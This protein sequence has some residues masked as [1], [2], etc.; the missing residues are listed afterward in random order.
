MVLTKRPRTLRRHPGQIAFPGGMIESTDANALDAALREAR[1]EIGFRP[2]GDVSPVAL[3]PVKTLT[4]GIVIHPF[5]IE[6]GASPRLRADPNEVEEILRVPTVALQQ[7]RARGSVAYPRRSG[8]NI[9]AFRWNGEVIWGVTAA[10]IDE[11]LQLY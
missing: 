3:T 2:I 10:T 5:L 9:V 8:E 11:V 6:L 4:S 7:P 1:E